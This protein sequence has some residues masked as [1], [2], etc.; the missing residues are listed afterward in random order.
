MTDETRKLGTTTKDKKGAHLMIIPLNIVMTYPVR[1]NKYEVFRDFIQNFYDAVGFAKW[2]QMFGY[3]FQN[4]TLS[5][6]V[7]GVFFSYEWLLHIGASTKTG[8]SDGNAG[9]FGEGFKIASLCALRDFSW[10]ITMFSDGWKLHVISEHHN[11]DNIPVKMLAYDVQTD[12]EKSEEKRSLLQIDGIT[13]SEYELFQKTLLSFYHPENRFF[14]RKLWAGTEGAV[15]ERSNSPYDDSLPSTY[16]FGKTGLVY[17]G[18]QLLGTNPFKLV[19]CL[20]KYKKE[21][22]ER[23]ALYSFQVIDVFR[24]IAY[25]VDAY[26]AMCMLEKMRKYW[27][28]YP[29]KHIDI[30]SW[31]DV[32]DCLIRKV[33]HSDEVVSDFRKNYPNILCLDRIS[34][35]HE[36]NR[37]SQARSWLERQ[38]KKYILAKG[39]FSLLGYPSLEEE[40]EKSGGFVL[41]DT[42]KGEKERKY[43]QVIEGVIGK[44]YDGFF[45]LEQYPERRLILNEKATYHGMATIYKRSNPVLN[46]YGIYIRYDV[47]K[48]YLKRS[49][50]YKNGYYDAL[51][52]YV[53]EMCHMFGGDA[54]KT[55][56]YGLTTAMELLLKNNSAVEKGNLLWM[57][58]EEKGSQNYTGDR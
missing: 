26:G 12:L 46:R 52:T 13:K 25:H 29:H 16:E 1:W 18:Y 48:I 39:T 10:S 55:F 4:G 2:N 5:M 34:T 45:L 33:S 54:S 17:C 23:R 43:F 14:G 15:Y 22:R 3:E 42:V 7:D 53:H 27:N 49:I 8:N 28:S 37:R 21:D 19:V 38:N 47:G 36:K 31:S 44:V 35:T 6:W 9:Y 30:H 56:S 20:H 24:S 50:L 41:D 58:V 32:I 51:A 57:G 11:I 40:C